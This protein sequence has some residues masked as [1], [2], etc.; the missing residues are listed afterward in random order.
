MKIVELKDLDH[1]KYNSVVTLGFFDGMHLGHQLIFNTLKNKALK[2][3]YKSVVITFSDDVL[4]LF[5][6]SDSITSLNDKL[7]IFEQLG[8]DYCLVLSIKDNFMNLSAKEFI[9][10]YL[11]KLNCKV[12]ACGSDFSFA[13]KKEG[14]INFIKENTDYEVILVD[15][16]YIDDIKISSTLIRNLLGQG[17]IPLANKLLYKGFKITSKV[18]NG[19]EIGRTIGYK[20]ANLKITPSC[21][22]LKHGV[23]FASVVINNNIYKAMVNV[24]FNPTINDNKTLKVEVHILDFSSNLYES[25]I[26][27]S[28]I[29]YH[30]EEIK[31]DSLDKLKEQLAKDEKTLRNL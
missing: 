16:V 29:C 30:R 5:K 21:N 24:G 15:D 26:D 9:N 22:L 10:N 2:L 28:F 25:V 31:F 19:K 20:T 27:V 1:F 6:M 11:E 17:N 7:E 14:N 3:G 13:K 4:E 8:I 12:I 23:Y 18:I